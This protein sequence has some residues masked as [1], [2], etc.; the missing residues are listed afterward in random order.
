MNFQPVV[1][2][3]LNDDWNMILRWIMPYVAQPRLSDGGVPT[4]G[5]SDIVASVFF[6][7]AKPGAFIWGAGPVLLLPT[8]ADP[9]LGSGKWAVGPTA[10]ILK[11]SGG[12]TYGLLANHL[13]SYAGDDFT[14]GAVRSDVNSTFL[15]RSPTTPPRMPSR[16]ASTSKPRRTGKRKTSGRCRCTSRSPN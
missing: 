13:W 8:T 4:S 15:Q 11:Q 2:F 16:M 3:G 5:L 10:V 12:W 9:V 1:P 7:P 6:S 14:G